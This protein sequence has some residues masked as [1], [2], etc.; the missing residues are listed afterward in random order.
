M[1]LLGRR[2]F[3]KYAVSAGFLPVLLHTT[4]HSGACGTQPPFRLEALVDFVDDALTT[5]ITPAHVDAMMRL[6]SEMGV[7]RVSWAYYGDG[8]G[9]Y[10]IPSGLSR[11]WQNYADTLTA[12]DN[13]LRIAAE[14]AHRNGIELYA[15]YKPYETGPALSLPE[16]SPEARAFGRIKQQGGWLAWMDP[17]VVEHPDLRIRHKADD[18][19]QDLSGTPVSAIKLIKKDDSPTRITREHLQIWSS[20]LNYRYRQ[21]NVDFTVTEKVERCPA[22]V[23]NL[24]GALVTREGD[25]VRVLTMSGFN[26]TDPYILVTTDFTSGPADF[27]NT[28]TELLAALDGQGKR[29]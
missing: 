2:N 1:P 18:S 16:G 5:V 20:N 15:Y 22:E 3:L 28:G 7:T 4:A 25:P 12:L 24:N 26:L 10:F 19:I 14:A 21:L 6:L 17:F 9:G 13:P 8:H 11:R 29:T 27:E 23:R